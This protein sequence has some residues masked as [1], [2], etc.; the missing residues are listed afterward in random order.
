MDDEVSDEL[1]DPQ[2]PPDEVPAEVPR[3]TRGVLWIVVP[4]L[5]GL[6]LGGLVGI[7]WLQGA[8]PELLGLG[9]AVLGAMVY[10]GIVGLVVGAAAGTFIWVCFPYKSSTA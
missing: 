4:A 9:Q 6:F 5:A 2:I 1:D 3:E 7:A 8:A 10:G